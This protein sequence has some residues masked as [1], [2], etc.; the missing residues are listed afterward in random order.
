MDGNSFG[1]GIMADEPEVQRVLGN[2]NLHLGFEGRGLAGMG[3]L[4]EAVR[5]TEPVATPVHLVFC[6]D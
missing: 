1:T 5:W 2:K 3:C 6:R 4:L